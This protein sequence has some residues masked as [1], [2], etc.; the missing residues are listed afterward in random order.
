MVNSPVDSSGSRNPYD[1]KKRPSSAP[2]GKGREVQMPFRKTL[3][4]TPLAGY[5]PGEKM[6]R[7][8]ALRTYTING[9][10]AAFEEEK[11]EE[12]EPSF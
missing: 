5:E 10:Y 8:L 11:I 9:A 3:N 2:P 1:I 7:D 4:K 12:M 6:S